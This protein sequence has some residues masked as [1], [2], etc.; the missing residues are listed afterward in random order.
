MTQLCISIHITGCNSS[1]STCLHPFTYMNIHSNY[2][3]PLPNNSCGAVKLCVPQISVQW[4]RP[5]ILPP[6]FKR[7]NV[8]NVCIPIVYPVG[9]IYDQKGALKVQFFDRHAFHRGQVPNSGK[10]FMLLRTFGNQEVVST[11]KSSRVLAVF[12]VQ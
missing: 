8:K 10:L 4:G 1:T 11:K 5:K 7:Y 2:A 12:F 6:S 3:N 9:R